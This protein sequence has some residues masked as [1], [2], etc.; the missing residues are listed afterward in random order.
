METRQRWLVLGGLLT[1]TLAAAAWVH[2]NDN[3]N[4]VVVESH[5]RPG[6]MARAGDEGRTDTQLRNDLPRIA[7]EG[8]GSQQ[9]SDSRVQL[10][11]LNAR[12]LG[13]SGRD[14]FAMPVRK[15]PRKRPN[16]PPVVV[17][18]VAPPPPPSA[19]AL[20][21]KY[22]GKLVDGDETKVFLIHGDRNLVV[23]AGDT[24]ESVY[25]LD[26]ISDDELIL[27]YLPMNQRQT[28]S[29]RTPTPGVSR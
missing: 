15:A 26:R 4:Q 24:I 16:P 5:E 23:R 9:R 14:P 18:R 11:R 25:R 28:L 13:K 7:G 27:T 17:A 3:T 19:P 8:A 21:F 22:M 2:G 1:A 10:E 20:P 12:T 6:S 29:T